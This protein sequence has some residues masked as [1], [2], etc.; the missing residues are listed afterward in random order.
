[1]VFTIGVLL[2]ALPSIVAELV[3]LVWYAY[4]TG[5][6][7]MAG[8]ALVWLVSTLALFAFL[9]S[10][11]LTAINGGEVEVKGP[12]LAASLPIAMWLAREL[13]TGVLTLVGRVLA[14]FGRDPLDASL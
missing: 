8:A 11:V 1:L 9:V 14:L 10:G 2:R 4:R 6:R 13:V 12:M 3:S 7:S 5:D